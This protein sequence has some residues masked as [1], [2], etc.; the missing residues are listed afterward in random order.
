[1]DSLARMT[2][3]YVGRIGKI[4]DGLIPVVEKKIVG[5]LTGNVLI[6]GLDI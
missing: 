4:Y 5:R 1:M 6:P 2:K 3:I